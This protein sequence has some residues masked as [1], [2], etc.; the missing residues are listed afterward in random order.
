MRK[1]N[2]TRTVITTVAIVALVVLATVVAIVATTPVATFGGVSVATDGNINL[3]F[4]YT[5]SGDSVTEAEAII[6][7]AGLDPQTIKVPLKTAANGK[8][9]FNVPLAAAQMGCDVTVTP[10]TSTGAPACESKTFSVRDYAELV[11]KNGDHSKYYAAVKSILNYGT[12]AHE[13]FKSSVN[14]SV[15][16]NEGVYSRLTNPVIN[17]GYELGTAA[18]KTPVV[19]AE[20]VSDAYCTLIL[21]SYVQIRLYYTYTGNGTTDG[22]RVGDTN[23]YYIK[24]GNISTADYA[25]SYNIKANVNG[26]EAVSV[27]VSVIDCLK[28]L[29]ADAKTRDIAHAMYY[30]YLNTAGSDN[31]PSRTDCTHHRQHYE[32]TTIGATYSQAT[33]SYCGKIMSGAISDDVNYYS[34]PGQQ[35]NKTGVDGL[36]QVGAPIGTVMTEGGVTFNRVQVTDSDAFEFSNGSAVVTADGLAIKNSSGNVVGDEILGGSGRYIVFK[37]RFSATT[38]NNVR[39]SLTMLADNVGRDSAGESTLALTRYY[40]DTQY[41]NVTAGSWQIYVIDIEKLASNYYGAGRTQVNNVSLGMYFLYLGQ[42]TGTFDLAYFAVCD[43]W[44]E[45]TS[46]VDDSTVSTVDWVNGKKAYNTYVAT[47]K[48]VENHDYSPVIANNTYS[49][50]CNNFICAEALSFDADVNYFSAPGQYYNVYNTGVG[51]NAGCSVAGTVQTSGGVTYQSIPMYHVGY[52]EF[53]NGTTTPVRGMGVNGKHNANSSVDPGNVINGGIGEYFVI[54][55]KSSGITKLSWLGNATDDGGGECSRTNGTSTARDIS[56]EVSSDSWTVY[57]VKI[58]NIDKFTE[59]TGGTT[60]N[61]VSVG[62]STTQTAANN[63]T[64]IGTLDVAY[65]A[66]CDDW[67]EIA[68]VV[69]N[70]NVKYVETWKDGAAVD[71]NSS[72][73]CDKCNIKLTKDGNTYTY[74]CS[75]CKKV[76]ETRTITSKVNYF[77]T[78][79]QFYNQWAMDGKGGT[80][81][82]FGTIEYDPA[83]F[84]YTHSSFTTGASFE[85]TNGTII[86]VRGF[87]VN[88]YKAGSGALDLGD[89]ITGEG[90]TGNYIVLKIRGSISQMQFM[91]NS[92][93]DGKAN[94]DSLYGAS[95][96]RT[97]ISEEISNWRVYVCK[98]PTISSNGIVHYIP[99][100]TTAE[101][102]CIGLQLSGTSLDVAYMAVCD[103]WEEIQSIV[104][105][106]TVSYLDNWG[107]TIASKNSDGTCIGGCSLTLEAQGNTY[108]YSCASCEQTYSQT[109]DSTINFY[110]APGQTSNNWSTGK[111]QNGVATFDH[112][113]RVENGKVFERLVLG[114]GASFRFDNNSVATPSRR[115]PAIAEIEGGTGQY[116]VIRCRFNNF[117][118]GSSVGWVLNSSTSAQGSNTGFNASDAGATAARAFDMLNGVWQTYVIDIESLGLPYYNANDMGANKI[119]IGMYMNQNALIE[120]KSLDVEYV[121]ICD[122]WAE[123]N[124]LVKEDTVLYSGWSDGSAWT[125]VSTATG[126]RELEEGVEDEVLF[127]K[128]GE[129]MYIYVR[130]NVEGVNKYTRYEFKRMVNESTKFDSWKI[131][132]ID[133]CDD[134]LNFLY[135]TVEGACELEAAIQEKLNYG[136]GKAAADFIG[137]YHG[138]EYMTSIKIIVDGKE[139]NMNDNYALT[140]CESVQAVVESYLNRCTVDYPTPEK[141]FDRVKIDTWTKDGLV[142]YNKFTATADIFVQRPATSM[143]AIKFGTGLITELRNTNLDW[144]DIPDYTSQNGGSDADMA[145]GIMNSVKF[146]TAGVTWAEFRGKL[147]VRVE[148]SDYTVNGVQTDATGSFSYDYFGANSRRVKIYIEPFHMKQLYAGDVLECTSTQSIFAAE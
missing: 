7:D 115:Y 16:E 49:H 20:G 125:T 128:I 134:K 12:Y 52:F 62:L 67:T 27:N 123:I 56:G 44:Q 118:N 66:I 15:V 95:G 3:R 84:V 25:K 58:S 86:P 54:K 23:Q 10:L 88:G 14:N 122:S 106:D 9:Y 61:K 11:L 130:S 97:G 94:S 124:K 29:A 98:I 133:I 65:F 145:S 116:I 92:T 101:R 108:T 119:A 1:L 90:G 47:G 50:T 146:D 89:L 137:G 26:A 147:N 2:K 140:A 112:D 59:Y 148:M 96:Y 103:D 17:M 143:L 83:G 46:L 100:D 81:T 117:T 121:A 77:S 93:D 37:Y 135:T 139:I 36:T 74:A 21:D 51:G 144:A 99:G 35:V 6:S 48:C 53:V 28:A 34:A 79:G 132:M 72:G 138:D 127:E 82:T 80:C 105:D 33:C 126:P 87:S 41:S 13:Y 18:A 42:R 55:L 5:I 91:M 43:D 8:T 68:A 31:V 38:N 70:E 22:T 131:S 142:I 78:A 30:Y 40:S 114:K 75:A 57:V 107:G 4:Y 113:I 64:L 73:T 76:Y 69:G 63:T 110:S 141:V 129:K 85:F 104:G 32:A 24:V 71:L 45:V 39:M 102:I 120:G 136:T 60:S 111:D 19:S 109:V